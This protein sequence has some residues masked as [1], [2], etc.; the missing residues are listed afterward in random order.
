MAEERMRICI[1]TAKK[2]RKY[3]YIQSKEGGPTYKDEQNGFEM[4]KEGSYWYASS[5]SSDLRHR[6]RT[7]E[8]P[9]M[10]GWHAWE[11]W[12]QKS[13]WQSFGSWLTTSECS[14]WGLQVALGR[15]ARTV[16]LM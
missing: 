4:F 8:N 2:P 10:N 9:C 15:L 12:T 5:S 7:A 16:Q 6:F 1:G 3:C 14:L 13:G 11:E